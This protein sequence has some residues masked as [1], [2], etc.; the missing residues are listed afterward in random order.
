MDTVSPYLGDAAVES[1]GSDEITTKLFEGWVAI[2]DTLMMKSL[3]TQTSPK[4][5]YIFLY[6]AKRINLV[7]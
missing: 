6:I 3:S 7:Q 5:I 1:K 2:S 4:Y